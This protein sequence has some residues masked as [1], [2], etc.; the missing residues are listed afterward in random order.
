M[1]DEIIKF[2]KKQ[3]RITKIISIISILIIFVLYSLIGIV[4][5]NYKINKQ[6]ENLKKEI[7]ELKENN[8]EQQSKILYYAT[9]AYI[10]KVLREKLGY[11]KEGERVYA[12]PRQD[13][14]REKLIKEQKK[15]QELEERKS[16]I[17]KWWDWFF[18]RGVE[19]SGTCLPAGRA[20]Q[21][22]NFRIM[23]TT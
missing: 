10:E 1:L 19:Q 7:A 18:R 2:I 9:N 15:Y 16:N 12:L 4:Y 3:N 17:L 23:P 6:I 20:R 21:A 11:Q 22:H 13:P 5:K 8:I 14:E